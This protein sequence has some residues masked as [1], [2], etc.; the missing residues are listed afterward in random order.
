MSAP[1]RSRPLT[2][3]L[4]AL[5]VL[6]ALPLAACGDDEPAATTTAVGGGSPVTIAHKFGRTTVPADPQR[7]VSVGFG[8]QDAVLALG[9]VPLGARDWYGEQ[10][11][12]SFPWERD[13]WGGRLP[14]VVGDTAEV[15]Y[16]RI[17]ALR[18]DLIVGVTSAMDGA[19]YAKLAKIAPTVAQPASFKDSESP[20]WQQ[21]TE[22]VGRALGREAQARELVRDVE[23]RFATARERRPEMARMTG[24]NVA[25]SGNG[26]F[27]H[28][29]AR[30]SRGRFLTELG[31]RVPKALATRA[32]WTPVS[33]ERLD[34]FDVDVLFVE[35]DAA[36]ERRFRREKLYPS[37]DVVR[38]GDVVYLQTNRG[39]HVGEAVAYASV[40]SLPY[41]IDRVM[42]Q[43]D[44]VLE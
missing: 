1:P 43:L 37:L 40:L 18:P 23:R 29:H 28:Y 19:T 31:F 35:S 36:G 27:D 17:A 11:F 10:P 30:D 12:G 8:E 44:R 39:D 38:R 6:L 20:P 5:V 4:L 7:V 9:I 3:L 42:A 41:A 22:L 25:P 33:S 24:I 2:R 14:Q 34:L 13:R 26:T 16:E 32:D 15:D 21:V